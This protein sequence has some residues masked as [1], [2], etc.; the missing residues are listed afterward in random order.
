MNY[1]QKRLNALLDEAIELVET[2]YDDYFGLEE[3]RRLKRY[4]DGEEE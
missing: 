1:L 4:F 3:L 2:E